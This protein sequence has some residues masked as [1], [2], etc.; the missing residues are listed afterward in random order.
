MSAAV[1]PPLAKDALK[2][3]IFLYDPFVIM[4]RVWQDENERFLNSLRHQRVQELLDNNDHLYSLRFHWDL[5]ESMSK[6]LRPA[7]EARGLNLFQMVCDATRRSPHRLSPFR[8]RPE[9]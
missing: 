8:R 7:L 1:I 2:S 4:E 6:I 9:W 3:S 5:V